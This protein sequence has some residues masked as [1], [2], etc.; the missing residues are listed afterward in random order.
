MLLLSISMDHSP[1]RVCAYARAHAI[2]GVV[3]EKRQKQHSLP[4]PYLPA[5]QAGRLRARNSRTDWLNNFRDT[6]TTMGH[7]LDLKGHPLG[8]SGYYVD[9]YVSVLKALLAFGVGEREALDRI[10]RTR[11]AGGRD[12]EVTRAGVRYL[13]RQ[14]KGNHADVYR[15]EG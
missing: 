1:L 2:G 6:G 12:Y 3:T 8:A 13:V 11:R 15:L 9:R 7:S 5:R 10:E 4:G 14:M